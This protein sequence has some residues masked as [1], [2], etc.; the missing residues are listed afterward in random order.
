MIGAGRPKLCSDTF[1]ED[2]PYSEN[3]PTENIPSTDDVHSSGNIPLED[4]FSSDNIRF[5]KKIL[6]AETLSSINPIPQIKRVSVKGIPFIKITPHANKTPL[7]GE[8]HALLKEASLAKGLVPA[9]TEG[10]RSEIDLTLSMFHDFGRLYE[11][12]WLG[13]YKLSPAQIIES[14]ELLHQRHP[15]NK[16]VALNLLNAYFWHKDNEVALAGIKS[17]AND[18]SVCCNRARLY[19]HLFY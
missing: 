4:V 19:L 3:T 10:P 1:I 9:R 11:Y 7:T 5:P 15:N 16:E 12:A 14:L 13:G 8:V 17:L 18:D 6:S 2:V